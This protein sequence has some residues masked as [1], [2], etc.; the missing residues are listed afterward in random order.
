MRRRAVV[1]GSVCVFLVCAPLLSGCWDRLEIEE[2]GT[3]L[4]IAVDPV[5]DQMGVESI[6]GP[7][8]KGSANGF[9]V[10]AQ[11]AIPG[12]I[13]LGP[14]IGGGAGAAVKPVWI[15]SARGKTLD[16]AMNRLQEDLAN[17]LFLGQMRLV[18]VNQD[19][20]AT[21]GILPDIL[22]YLRRH[23]ETRRMLWLIISKNRAKD[24]LKA[25]PKLER[26]PTLYLVGMMDHS[27]SLGKIPDV[28]FGN[29]WGA[30]SSSGRDPL[31]PLISVRKNRIDMEGMAIFRG[32]TMIG[33]LN[34]LE[35]ASYMELANQ[36]IGGYAFSIPMPGDPENSVVLKTLLRRGKTLLKK[37]GG[38]PEFTIYT[39]IDC[40]IEEM[41]SVN[42]HLS[43]RLMEQL[44]LEAA[45]IKLHGQQRLIKK[46]QRLHTD[47]IGL[48]EVVR[49]EY[50]AY[51]EHIQTRER[52]HEAF[53][54][55]P[56]HFVVRV[57]VTRSG[58][59]TH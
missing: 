56:V 1:W 55:V 29:Y 44:S 35:I 14:A 15:L 36:Q 31:L 59:T 13:P 41:T 49:G 21:T 8:V 2:R 27:V 43:G 48:G 40:S 7:H 52:W 18:I 10:S 46:L 9:I 50:P 58:L 16:D 22:D 54:T 32:H 3:V 42:G 34:P 12:R 6:T 39:T 33:S 45:R 53:A 57:N 17:K 30:D 51:W 24:A 28:F 25:A 23:A 11:I 47:I 4:G 26:V 20:A 37:N 19:I 38:R 5:Q